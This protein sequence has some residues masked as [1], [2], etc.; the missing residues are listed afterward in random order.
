MGRIYYTQFNALTVTADDSQDLCSIIAGANNRVRLL[1]F[2]F[3]SDA[4]SSSIIDLD[5]RRITSAGTGGTEATEEP[6]DEDDPAA[7]A[8]V[9]QL[10]GTTQGAAGD[11]IMAWQW[12]QLGPVNHVF[13]D[14]REITSKTSEGFAFSWNTATAATV[15]GWICW[16]EL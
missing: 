3:T 9:R 5:L 1:E 14:Q 8:T 4:V 10:D 13:G 2:E 16:E 12:E 7:T 15:S 11:G 6:A